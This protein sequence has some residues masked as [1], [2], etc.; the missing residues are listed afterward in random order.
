MANK[1]DLVQSLYKKF[2][3]I[4][5]ED[6]KYMLEVT[7]KYMK[8]QISDGNRIELRGFGSFS[9]RRRKYAKKD[10]QYNTI[11]YRMSSKILKDL[12]HEKNIRH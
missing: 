11:Y 3:N 6:I 8:E 4:S 12:N 7:S 2:H 1:S 5:M 9:I 10:E